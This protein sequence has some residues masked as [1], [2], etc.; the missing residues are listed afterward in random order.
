M[1]GKLVLL[2]VWSSI[3]ITSRV[4]LFCIL[5]RSHF[6]ATSNTFKIKYICIKRTFEVSE[7]K[8]LSSNFKLQTPDN[9]GVYFFAH[10]VKH[11]FTTAIITLAI[12]LMRFHSGASFAQLHFLKGKVAWY[13]NRRVNKPKLLLHKALMLIRNASTF[14]DV[15]FSPD[16]ED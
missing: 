14:I 12:E 2:C 15:L 16:D 10:F 11:N 3:E 9:K 1:F 4:L 8:I 13:A 6:C 5:G 7:Q